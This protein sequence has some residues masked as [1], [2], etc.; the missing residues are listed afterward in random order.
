M[1]LF[2]LDTDHL[3]LLQHG[4]PQVAARLREVKDSQVAVSIVTYEEQVRGRL[5]VVRQAQSPERLA[6]AY[7]RLREAH[8]F[9]LLTDTA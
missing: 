4:H 3:T 7:L 8:D 1:A 6:I 5:A 9:F 2:V